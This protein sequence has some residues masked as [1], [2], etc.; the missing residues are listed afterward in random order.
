MSGAMIKVGIYGLL[1]VL[2]L[3]SRPEPWW[4]WVLI[5]IGASSGSSGCYSRWRSTI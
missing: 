2:T 1:R 3:A 4:G 5:A